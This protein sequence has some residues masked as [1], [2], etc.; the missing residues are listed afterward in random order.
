VVNN[1][2]SHEVGS[3]L[4]AL[5]YCLKQKHHI[6]VKLASVLHFSNLMHSLNYNLVDDFSSVPIYKDHP[7]VND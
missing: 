1:G 6:L 5:I 4:M 3:S 2:C 7:L